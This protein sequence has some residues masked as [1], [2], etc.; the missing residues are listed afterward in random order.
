MLLPCLAGSLSKRSCIKKIWHIIWSPSQ[1][2]CIVP[3]T[4]CIARL[5]LAFL[6]CS[7]WLLVKTELQHSWVIC[8]DDA[9]NSLCLPMQDVF[10]D[11]RDLIST[12]L[13]L[14]SLLSPNSN[15]GTFKLPKICKLL[16]QGTCCVSLLSK[17]DE[18]PWGLLQKWLD[19]P[20]TNS[21]AEAKSCFF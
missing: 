4:I 3:L 2:S 8:E 13:Y 20:L 7:C 19:T 21:I 15:P 1:P 16:S 11:A 6:P 12:L 10:A 18:A 14:L 5:M 17:A 9:Q